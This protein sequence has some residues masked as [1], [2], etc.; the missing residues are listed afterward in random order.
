[1]CSPA[2]VAMGQPFI[3]AW[4]D[5]VVLSSGLMSWILGDLGLPSSRCHRDSFQFSAAGLTVNTIYIQVAEKTWRGLQLFPF[6][7]T[8]HF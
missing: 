3:S 4:M 8:T 7:D 2:R 5:S 1:M 6:G